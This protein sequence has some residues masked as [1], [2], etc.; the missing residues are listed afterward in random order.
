MKRKPKYP[1]DLPHK[2]YVYFTSYSAQTGAP[3]FLKFARSVGLTLEDL[4][5]FREHK[6]FDKAYRECAAIRRDYLID[7][8][9]S[10]RFD[11]SFTKF[12]LGEIENVNEKTGDGGEFN[13]TLKVIDESDEL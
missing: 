10:K 1:K 5:S 7:N 12:L 4:E 8:A 13:L 2:L 3:S 9:L 6:E 11:S